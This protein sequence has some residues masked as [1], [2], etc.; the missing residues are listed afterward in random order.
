MRYLTSSLGLIVLTAAMAV[1]V[2]SRKKTHTGLSALLPASRKPNSS[3]PSSIPPDQR[4]GINAQDPR[5]NETYLA[6]GDTPDEITLLA[7]TH[8]EE[9]TANLSLSQSQR[10]KLLPLILRSSP[11][12]EDTHSYPLRSQSGVVHA[13]LGPKLSRASFEDHLFSLLD[14][15]QQLDY[16]AS[17]V[18]REIWWSSIISRLEED[19]E[20]QTNVRDHLPP[21]GAHDP[22]EE[23]EDVPIEPQPSGHRGRNLFN[24]SPENNP[25]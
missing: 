24:P 7:K 21:P 18:E 5:P 1:G 3:T 13:N 22:P 20:N 2:M 10:R 15:D 12:Y 17:V 11:G 16:A 14:E 23:P 4:T 9:L 6:Y 8:L 19:L 25:E